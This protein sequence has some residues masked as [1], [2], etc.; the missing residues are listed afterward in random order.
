MRNES[1]VSCGMQAH[2]AQKRLS[3]E[4]FSNTSMCA[5][6]VSLQ[7][8]PL[9]WSIPIHGCAPWLREQG[10]IAR[11]SSRSNMEYVHT[12]TAATEIY[13]TN[14]VCKHVR[15]MKEKQEMIAISTNVRHFWNLNNR[16]QNRVKRKQ[17][18]QI[19]RPIEYNWSKAS[20]MCV[21][22]NNL[23]AYANKLQ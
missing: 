9:I 1:T 18:K 17:H 10:N 8:H 7:N 6:L 21:S 2:V 16:H 15:S 20:E 4:K 13:R 14:N 5:H 12:Y 19:Q 11:I 23:W 22:A 3:R